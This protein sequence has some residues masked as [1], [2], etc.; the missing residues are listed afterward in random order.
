MEELMDPPDLLGGYF[1]IHFNLRTHLWSV[2]ALAGSH[3]GRVIAHL[4]DVTV[5][6]AKLI[7]SEA[8]HRRVKRIGQR[9]VHAWVRGHVQAVN[10]SPSLRGLT[11]ISYNPRPKEPDVFDP[12]FRVRDQ[13]GRPGQVVTECDWLVLAKPSAEAKKGYGWMRAPNPGP[14]QEVIW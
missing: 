10:S 5:T 14:S 9:T 11:C 4:D 13:G 7:V 1:Q 6:R 12:Y 2:T 3:K 8:G